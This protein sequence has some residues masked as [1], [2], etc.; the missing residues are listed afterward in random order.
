MCSGVVPQHPPTIRTP[1]RSTNLAM[2]ST[3]GPGASG[4]SVRPSTRIGSPAL[5]MTETGRPV[6]RPIAPQCFPSH[7]RCSAISTGPVAQFSPSEQMGYS[8]TAAAAAAISV[9]RSIVPV[10]SMVTESMIGTSWAVFPFSSRAA[11]TAFRTHLTWRRSWQVSTM[12]ASTPP[13]SSP[14]ACSR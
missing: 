14:R 2:A 10:A 5:G 12:K 1:S 3:N 13:A 6:R 8:A 7:W 4:Y 11:R 9:P